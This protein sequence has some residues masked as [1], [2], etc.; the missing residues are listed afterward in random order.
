VSPTKQESVGSAIQQ[1]GRPFKI[2]GFFG[3]T[4]DE[5]TFFL[6]LFPKKKKKME[7][8]AFCPFYG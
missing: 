1:A 5:R 7:E 3:K 2:C 6:S 8:C 4:F